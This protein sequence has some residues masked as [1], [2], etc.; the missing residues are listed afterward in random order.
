MSAQLPNDSQYIT[1]I[2]HNPMS[3]WP[4]DDLL[5]N[6]ADRDDF[7]RQH[8]RL[9]PIFDWPEMRDLFVR[10]NDPA[11]AARKQSRRAGVRAVYL[12]GLSLALSALNPFLVSLVP[13]SGEIAQYG[14]IILGVLSAG[15]AVCSTLMG[16]AQVM[17]G[18]QKQRWLINR[19]WAERIRQFHFQAVINNLSAVV[20]AIKNGTELGK[21]RELREGEFK[22]FQYAEQ[23]D[24]ATVL[25]RL[26]QDLA[27]DNVWLNKSWA[28]APAAP[29]ESDDLT[30]LFSGLEA[31]RFDVQIRY[32]GDK[33]NGGI[34]SPKTRA[35]WFLRTSDI[36]TSV[37]VLLT[38][39]T[40]LSLAFGADSKSSWFL[41]IVGLGGVLT[42]A[43]V[44]LRVLN[45]GLQL[46]AE[47]ERYEWYVASVK[48]IKQRFAKAQLAEKVELL[49]EMER[50]SYQEMRRFLISYKNAR[51][52]M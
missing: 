41:L 30:E 46:R 50:L 14:Q 37:I 29:S 42:A 11:V 25:N 31:L 40:G 33:L 5:L 38:A 47:T 32:V 36:L 10:H 4:N 35:G 6:P 19:Y 28:A 27:E 48:S 13:P 16:V 1:P 22:S 15:L 26:E 24:I 2:L 9:A 20:T 51:F 23:K 17:S 3:V 44:S 21:W 52:I 49:R 45:E 43:V 12:G 18:D 34:F 8:P 7:A 39:A